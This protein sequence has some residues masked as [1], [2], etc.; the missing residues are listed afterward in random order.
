MLKERKGRR[1]EGGREKGREGKKE[2]RKDN[3]GYR[4]IKLVRVE[5]WS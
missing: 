1:E 5:L 2:G 3:L 4:K